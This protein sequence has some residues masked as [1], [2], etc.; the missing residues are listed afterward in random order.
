M[1]IKV[2][3]DL[4]MS[5]LA[6]NL[7]RLMASDMKGHSHQTAMTMHEKFLYNSATIK[8]EEEQITVNMKKKR[9]LP[10]LLET[11]NKYEEEKYDWL[12]KK[13]IV[14]NGETST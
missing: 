1:V 5:I 7:Y 4:T 13:K 6:Y 14:F 10:L 3:F 9:N 11:I 12:D 8:V 2:D